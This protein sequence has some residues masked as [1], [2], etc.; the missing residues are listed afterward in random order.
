MG[1][2]RFMKVLVGTSGWNYNHWRRVFY[3]E[4]LPQNRWLEFYSKY[5]DTVEIN[6]TFYRFPMERAIEKW[7]KNVPHGFI[8]SVKGS[9]IITHV[10][11]LKDVESIFKK[12]LSLISIFENNLGPVLFQLP[13]SFSFNK[14]RLIGFCELLSSQEIIKNGMFSIELRDKRWLNE[15][16]F[17]ILK[18][19]NISLCFSDYPGVEVKS[20]LTASFVYI[21]RHGPTSLYSSCYTEKEIRKE[22]SFIENFLKNN[23]GV[24]IYYNNDANAWAV[25]NALQLKEM[26][27]NASEN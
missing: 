1:A 6:M 25:R 17:S 27:K 7:K 26:I 18:K 10:K 13:P 16:G 8:F 14:E 5:F 3:P 4:N 19:Y 20:P 22:A 15:E 9:R 2:F 23:I 11:K 24:F 21:R 12:F